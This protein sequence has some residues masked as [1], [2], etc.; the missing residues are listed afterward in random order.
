MA[1]KQAVWTIFKAR[2]NVSAAFKKMSKNSKRFGSDT[3]AAF[4]KASKSAKS[5]KGVTSGI[6]KAKAVTSGLALAKRGLEEVTRQ[7]IDFDDAIV[8]ASAKFKDLDLTT[9]AGQKRLLLLK[10]TARDV[11]AATQFSATEAAAG[12]DFLALAGF[13]TTQAM[14]ALPGIVDLAT[15]AQTDLG[16]AVDI[17]SDSLG[18]FGLMT[19]D[20]VQLQKNLIRVNDV[21]AKTMASTNTNLEDMFEA[22]KKGAPDFI[23]AGQSVETF[24]SL[25]G[26]MANSGVKGGEAG[27]KLRNVMTR[28]AKPTKEATT[29]LEN[30]KIGIKDNNNNFRD[31]VDILSDVEKATKKMGT[32]EK[33][34]VLATIF[35]ARNQGAINI[36]LREG[37]KNIRK[38]REGL[39]GAAGASKK[40]ADIMRQSLGNRL[41]SLQSAL[42]ELGFKVLGG[43]KKNFEDTIDSVTNSI[44]KFDVKPIVDGIRTVMSLISDLTQVVKASLIV[45]A[46]YG[47]GWTII[48]AKMLVTSGVMKLVAAGQWLLNAAMTAFGFIMNLSFGG[49]LILIGL[50]IIGII[51]LW[52]NWDKVSSFIIKT[53]TSIWNILKKVF[54]LA[55]K[56]VGGTFDFLFGSDDEEG[57]QKSTNSD[58]PLIFAP[59]NKTAEESKKVNFQ[60]LFKFDNAPDGMTAETKTFGAPSI[61]IEGL[62]AN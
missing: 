35:G 21:M 49:W 54:S 27:T 52:K 9:Q 19:E 42:I 58:K 45:L 10:K 37:T 43:F 6:L 30:M 60:G 13:K 50:I 51:L 32:A 62:G 46:L 5:F 48:N 34:R 7:F 29:E 61:P 2:D 23:S 20:S 44:R 4:K 12:L 38:F 55:G 41:K 57:K 39:I 16:R 56:L 33:A 1:F 40:M 8:S 59:P 11:G 3:E 25:L 24:S 28:L 22:I 17:A 53:A 47:T 14:A 15:V 31:A 26:I 36:L 18:A